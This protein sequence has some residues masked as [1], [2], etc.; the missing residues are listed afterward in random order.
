MARNFTLFEYASLSTLA[1]LQGIDLGMLYPFRMIAQGASR[2]A[3]ANGAQYDITGDA[4]VAVLNFCID[5]RR[6]SEQA[7]S[8]EPPGSALAVEDASGHNRK[9]RSLVADI[10]TLKAL[11]LVRAEQIESL[12]GRLGQADAA[13]GALRAQ[14][15]EAGESSWCLRSELATASAREEGSKKKLADLQVQLTETHARTD[16]LQAQLVEDSQTIQSMYAQANQRASQEGRL[17]AALKGA[18]EEADGL[19]R[20]AD[21]LKGAKEETDALRREAGDLQRRL[22]A[23]VSE[24]EGLR[25]RAKELLAESG[26]AVKQHLA[27]FKSRVG[28]V[29]GQVAGVVRQLASR[30]AALEAEAVGLRQC[31]LKSRST[32]TAA[33]AAERAATGQCELLKCQLLECKRDKAGSEALVEENRALTATVERQQADAMQLVEA[34]NASRVVVEENRALTA[35]VARLRADT[36]LL[37]EAVEEN[38]VLAEENRALTATVACMREDA[39]VVRLREDAALDAALDAEAG[40]GPWASDLAAGAILDAL[41]AQLHGLECDLHIVADVVDTVGPGFEKERAEW[42]ARLDAME[43]AC[44]EHGARLLEVERLK[45]VVEGGLQTMSMQRCAVELGVRMR[46]RLGEEEAR[47]RALIAENGELQEDLAFCKAE[48]DTLVAAFEN[49]KRAAAGALVETEWA[50]LRQGLKGRLDDIKA[51]R[52]QFA[53]R[54]TAAIEVRERDT[55]TCADSMELVCE[56]IR[57]TLVG[58][59][60]LITK[61]EAK[62]LRSQSRY[63]ESVK[64]IGCLLTR[65]GRAQRAR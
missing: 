51:S 14:L 33:E 16:V 35:T 34:V 44:R 61:L 53:A 23:S 47:S 59:D 32:A 17:E 10:K 40:A 37:V 30:T 1:D 45:R 19:R 20:E 25:A 13:C 3:G 49:L 46:Q 42:G 29:H 36:A 8:W 22:Q 60:E 58:K 50:A 24:T 65:L 7:G 62:C 4:F 27:E 12:E 26:E 15:V 2:V 5:A 48:Y 31:L 43:R 41:D 21:A 52:K 11:M 28:F 64:T 18:R 63:E 56:S 54:L 9:K 39:V 57:L 55:A 6:V 38:R